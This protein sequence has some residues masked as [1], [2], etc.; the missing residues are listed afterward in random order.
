M[1]KDTSYL[2]WNVILGGVN[3]NSVNMEKGRVSLNLILTM[4]NRLCN[5]KLPWA[6]G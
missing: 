6:D 3:R 4:P 1:H 5:I 2:V